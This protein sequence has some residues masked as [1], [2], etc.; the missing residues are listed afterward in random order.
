VVYNSNFVQDGMAIL[1]SAGSQVPWLDYDPLAGVVP[2]GETVDI[3]F[4]FDATGLALG[5][6][7]AEV[8]LTS[9]DAAN[10]TVV[11]PTRL[12]VTDTTLPVADLPLAFRFEGAAPNPFN[13]ATTLHFSLP[14]AGH[15]EL[16]VFDVQ[17]RLVRS[18]VDGQRPAGAGE[19]RWDGRDTD[20]RQVASGTYYARLAAAGRTSVKPLVLVK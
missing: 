18:L 4:D 7:H 12:T 5:D 16:R 20:G 6:H 8:T 15:V 9:N 1:L 2:S 19:A 10:P 17:G 11:I 13:P 14:A 3:A